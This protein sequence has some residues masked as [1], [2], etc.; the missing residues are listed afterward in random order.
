[1]PLWLRASQFLFKVI[2]VIARNVEV[3]SICLMTII[4]TLEMT[5]VVFMDER[6]VQ[7]GCSHLEHGGYGARIAIF[8]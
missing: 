8:E 4:S 7:K 5:S 2:E 1:M 6:L 3:I